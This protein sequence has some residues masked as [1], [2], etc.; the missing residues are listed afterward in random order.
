VQVNLIR[1]EIE[2]QLTDSGYHFRANKYYEKTVEK[3]IT[4]RYSKIEYRWWDYPRRNPWSTEDVLLFEGLHSKRL[5][6]EE[7][8][9]EI[10]PKT[11]K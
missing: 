10:F 7:S 2:I 8:L 6:L 9:K 11:L 1:P 5:A 4:N 3:G